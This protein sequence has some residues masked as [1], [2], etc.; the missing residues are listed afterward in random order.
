VTDPVHESYDAMKPRF[1]GVLPPAELQRGCPSSWGRPQE[2][3]ILAEAPS[4]IGRV[5]RMAAVVLLAVERPFWRVFWVPN[6]DR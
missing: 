5:N 3:L 6:A 4:A 1:I 2:E